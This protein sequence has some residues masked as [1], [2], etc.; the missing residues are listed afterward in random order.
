MSDVRVRTMTSSDLETVGK[1]A[2]RL[3]R[4][5]HDLD[6]KRFIHLENPEPGYARWLGQE[7]KN[8]AVVLI[9]AE[10]EGKVVG[11]VYARA[12]KRN[13]NDLLD[14]HGKLHDVYVDEAARGKGAGEMLVRETFRR[15]AEK[16]APRV[17][18]STAVQNAAAQRL[19][20]KVG[21]RTTMLEMTAEL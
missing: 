5:H 8:D 13:Y 12:E 2:G 7:M 1:L 19:F 4:M 14:A 10:L 3:V 11:Y 17:V 15:L 20:E 16:G 9:V 6:P 18:L 21:F